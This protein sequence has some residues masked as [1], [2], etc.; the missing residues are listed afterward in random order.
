LFPDF[1]WTL[2]NTS[3]EYIGLSM[4]Q[5]DN[6]KKKII[7]K[8]PYEDYPN[9]GP[10][11]DTTIYLGGKKRGL[12]SIQLDFLSKKVPRPSIYKALFDFVLTGVRNPYK[13][14]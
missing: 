14:Y 10:A 5:D 4:F 1:L 6:K 9:M 11:P 3:D 8:V 13:S 12:K 7:K 2:Q